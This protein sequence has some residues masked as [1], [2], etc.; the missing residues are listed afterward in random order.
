MVL[1]VVDVFHKDNSSID[2]DDWTMLELA[3]VV[4]VHG[5]FSLLQ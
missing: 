2:V 5:G 1:A 4:V 3:S